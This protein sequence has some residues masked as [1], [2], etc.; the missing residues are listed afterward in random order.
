MI[1]TLTIITLTIDTYIHVNIKYITIISIIKFSTLVTDIINQKT[2]Y[3]SVHENSMNSM[4]FCVTISFR[5]T[6]TLYEPDAIL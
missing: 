5:F 3:I 6:N 4:T 1:S 2:Y